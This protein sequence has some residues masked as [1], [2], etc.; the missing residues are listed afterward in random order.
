M[1]SSVLTHLAFAATQGA[2]FFCAIW[3]VS[4]VFRRMPAI[5]KCWLWRMVSVKF[6]LGLVFLISLPV[7]VAPQKEDN[8]AV[9]RVKHVFLNTAPGF[10]QGLAFGLNQAPSIRSLRANS[11]PHPPLISQKQRSVSS[12]ET[13]PA[14]SA[15]SAQA[16]PSIQ[17]STVLGAIWLAGLLIV[18]GRGA[19]ALKRVKGILQDS[20]DSPLSQAPEG[21]V[22]VFDRSGWRSN[23]RVRVLQDLAAPALLGLVKPTI[24]LPSDMDS[25]SPE[26]VSS[27]FAHE[28]AHL[29]RRD[30]AWIFFAE[31]VRAV[32]W[33]HPFAWLA[34]REQRI[35]AEIAADRLARTWTETSP[36]EYAGHLL[37][38]ID[39]NRQ[40]RI[41]V[42]AVP[43]LIPSTHEL[44]T[45]V[46]AMSLRRY[47]GRSSVALGTI[48]GIP[49]AVALAPVMFFAI[50]GQGL[51]AS[52]WPKFHGGLDNSGR[53][54]GSGAVGI[55]KWSFATSENAGDPAIGPDGTI[56][57]GSGDD[58]VYALDGS[59]GTKKW[60]FKTNLMVTSTPAVASDGT[61]YVGS[62]DQKL[63][64][65]NGETGA[66]KWSFATHGLIYPAP[67]IGLDGTVYIGSWDGKIYALNGANGVKKWEFQTA[68]PVTSDPAIGKDG[69][70]YVGSHGGSLYALNGATGAQKWSFTAEEATNSP[71]IGA[72]GTVYIGSWDGKVYALDGSNGT[73][74]WETQTGNEIYA[75]P[76][77]GLDGTV[78]IGSTDHRVYALDGK[79]GARKWAFVT[80]APV[81]GSPAIGSDGTIYVGSGDQHFYAIDGKTGAKIWSFAGQGEFNASPAIGADGTIYV[82]STDGTIYALH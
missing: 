6:A 56:Y 38:W 9:S 68:G 34:C 39:P 18:F 40:G 26:A 23:I 1:E 70:V 12:A 27:A 45:R 2:L 60:R 52:P 17:F 65:L 55:K 15:A 24:V 58:Y 36:R 69:T 50:T 72:D 42:A 22:R 29:K 67:T 32:F 13:P 14:T 41:S 5:W 54:A 4:R 63:Y 48:L 82:G 35:E 57:I 76:A 46:K 43:G 30:V 8:G 31:A 64:A 49:L 61:I 3:V 47:S 80:G 79:T 19:L 75:C 59:K 53:G 21:M 25:T 20:D 10:A 78:Y 77:V 33:F 7:V 16:G 73:K 44:I 37:E 81:E 71:S 28:L 74:K 66:K 62:Q 51:A 11:Q